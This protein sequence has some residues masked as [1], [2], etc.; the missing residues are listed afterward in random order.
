LLY[1]YYLY[2]SGIWGLI[3]ANYVIKDIKHDD[4]IHNYPII[5][6]LR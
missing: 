1:D 3:Y 2:G 4:F 6:I 5:C